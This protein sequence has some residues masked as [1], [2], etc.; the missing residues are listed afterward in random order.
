[1][2]LA[3]VGYWFIV[4]PRR[5]VG[6]CFLFELAFV[7]VLFYVLGRF[8]GDLGGMFYAGLGGLFYAVGLICGGLFYADLDD[9]FMV[10]F[11]AMEWSY[12]VV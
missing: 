11:G 2:V 1:M 10:T 12:A 8:Y 4:G 9:R 5:L 3:F 7:V 6:S